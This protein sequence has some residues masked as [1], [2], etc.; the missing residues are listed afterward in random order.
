MA[1]MALQPQKHIQFGRVEFLFQEVIFHILK[2]ILLIPYTV[3]LRNICKEI[4]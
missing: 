2:Q 3:N 1:L 4:W